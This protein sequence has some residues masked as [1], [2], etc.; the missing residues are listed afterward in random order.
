MT[1]RDELLERMD[2]AARLVVAY[3]RQRPLCPDHRD[4]AKGFPCLMCEIERLTKQR[5]DLGTMIRQLLR[6]A[7]IPEG[8][9]NQALGLVARFCPAPDVLREG[10]VIQ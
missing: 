5:D 4:K 9:E 10:E 6:S 3:E 7:D 8:I 2:A 1:K